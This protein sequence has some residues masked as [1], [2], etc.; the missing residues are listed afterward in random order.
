MH[1]AIAQ[2]AGERRRDE[3]GLALIFALFFAIIVVGLTVSGAIFMRAHKEQTQVAFASHGQAVEF[4]RS[5]LIEGLGWFRKQTAQPVTAF[6]PRL[7]ES[8][9]PQV[10]DTMEPEIGIV[11]EFQISGSLWGRYELWKNWTTDPDPER[12]AFRL[13]A[14]CEDISADRGNLTPG[15]VWRLRSFG[16]VFRRNSTSARFDQYPNRVIAREMVETEIRRL[17]MQ[18]PGQAALCTRNASTCRVQ[19][20]GRVFGGAEGAG[21]YYLRQ[22]TTTPSVSGTGSQVTGVPP[23][24]G[25]TTYADDY[26]SVFGVSLPELRGMAD[27]ALT[28][29]TSF[30]SP[31]PKDSLIVLDSAITFTSAQPLSGTGIVVINGDCT[32]SPA[33]YSAFSGLLYVRGSLTLREPS[34]IQGTVVVTGAVNVMGGSDFATITFDDGIVNRLRQTLGTYR[35]STGVMRPYRTDER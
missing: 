34:E 35:Q 23:T 1:Q 19:T 7:D 31:V 17:G 5:G 14:R 4:A 24:S 18:A 28:D 26:V 16:Y 15:S 21:I 6:V 13:S 10:L 22:G 29:P 2:H 9:T 3:R 33:S 32:I 25:A 11:R 12:R 20:R 27:A 30:P 8:A